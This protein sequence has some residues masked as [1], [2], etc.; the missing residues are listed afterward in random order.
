MSCHEASK[1]KWFE[2]VRLNRRVGRLVMFLLVLG[3]FFAILM[4]AVGIL[5]GELSEKEAL[6][7][8]MI[9][10]FWLY[11]MISAL[12]GYKKIENRIGTDGDYVY[13]KDY[14]GR[15]W[16]GK[17]SELTLAGG[18]VYAGGIEVVV[19][20]KYGKLLYEDEELKK[21]LKEAQEVLPIAHELKTM[22]VLEKL[23]FLYLLVAPLL[24]L[25]VLTR[26]LPERALLYLLIP[27]LFLDILLILSLVVFLNRWRKTRNP[28][29]PR[30]A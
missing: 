20:D 6:S 18:R 3:L 15:M 13:L 30:R 22:G 12:R 19:K 29:L 26:E 17:A 28:E 16:M 7:F 25:I 24:L 21:I 9:S 4:G 14:E 5:M 23:L 11:M 27:F 8:F 10:P 1:I 2:P